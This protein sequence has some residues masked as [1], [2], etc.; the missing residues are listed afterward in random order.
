V[1]GGKGREGRDLTRPQQFT[2]IRSA[3]VTSL[4]EKV[5]KR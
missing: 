5:E 1:K 4:K 2:T 3:D